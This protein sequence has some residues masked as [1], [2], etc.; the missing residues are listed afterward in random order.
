MLAR[1]HLCVLH[2]PQSTELLHHFQLFVTI[3]D[4]AT[5]QEG[6]NKINAVSDIWLL[7]SALQNMAPQ[8]YIDYLIYSDVYMK[9]IIKSKL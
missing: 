6:S 5:L 9:S 8:I 1:C 2:K 3:I 7:Q 4:N